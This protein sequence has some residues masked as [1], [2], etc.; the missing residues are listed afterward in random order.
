[1]HT[2]YTVPHSFH[3]P[4]MGTAFTID[5][6]IKVARFGISSVISLC[7]DELAETMR[8]HYLTTRNET[9]EP[10]GKFEEDARARRF[11]AY[12]NLVGAI[13]KE[14]IQRIKEEP[15]T[16]DSEITTYFELLPESSA[17]KSKYKGMLELEE[18]EE[19]S[20]QQTQLRKQ[21]KAGSIDVNIM[22]KLDRNTFSKEGEPLEDRFSDALSGL[23]G[24]AK[25]TL[26]AGIVFSAGFNRRLY[27]YIDQFEDFFPNEN[28]HVKKTII[29]KV[30]DYRSSLTQGKFLAKKGVWVA[31]HRIESGLNCGGHAFASDGY[32]LGPILDEFKEKRAEL[33]SALFQTCNGTLI[34]QG[35]PTFPSQPYTRI[36][37]QGGIG[38]HK[39]DQFL[40][41]HYKVD[42]TGWASPFLLV[43]EATTLDDETRDLLAAAPKEDF[44]LSPISPLGVP[45]NTVRGTQSETQKLERFEKG[46]P[47]SPCP[48]G[49]LVSNTEFTKKPICT[50]SV[51]YQK[52]KIEEVKK[53]DLSEQ[54]EK[55][56][57][58]EIIQ[59][60][61][62]CEDLA[63][64]SLSVNSLSNKRPLKT[65][66]CPGPN[67]A[68]FTSLHS[69]KDMVSHIYGRLNL[70]TVKGRSN[71]FIAELKM[72]V[73]Y[74]AKE[75]KKA[76]PEPDKGQRKYL[77]EFRK[78]LTAGMDYYKTLI[79]QI[80]FETEDLSEKMSQ[81]LQGYIE[82]V[83]ALL[84]EYQVA[85]TAA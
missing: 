62:L 85:F 76:L 31:E 23:R 39:E 10:I 21:V 82:E 54:D 1:M 49:F 34:K 65:A 55:D 75:I 58:F 29:L 4:V 27:A 33:A 53:Q 11:T 44:Y 68:N 22:T 78:N 73:D 80:N 74:F 46:R 57:I 36:T 48:K 5:S 47:G 50:A 61:C 26:E 51:L 9:F 79:P 6:P 15:F 45:F 24:F 83:E 52:R 13:V 25:S 35:K 84:N 77:E 32:L 67:L 3:I 38:T 30:S 8:E 43:K 28:G 63:A 64:G 81:E 17:L 70:I 20:A 72:Y 59:K 12:L 14:Q 71:M 40:H 69:L 60:V 66:V 19:K 7:D 56:R 41:D 42:G 16:P 37:V 2:K 18:G